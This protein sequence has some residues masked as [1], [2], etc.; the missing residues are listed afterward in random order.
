MARTVGGMVEMIGLD[1]TAVDE[2]AELD[3]FL[4][5]RGILLD[6]A[7]LVGPIHD[8]LLRFTGGYNRNRTVVTRVDPT[9]TQL[10]A[11][12]SAPRDQQFAG[13]DRTM[14]PG[15]NLAPC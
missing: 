10:A 5:R 2:L 8:R 11:L 6:F 3:E 12:S 9:P 1:T 14:V 7:E 15:T 4:E 13:E